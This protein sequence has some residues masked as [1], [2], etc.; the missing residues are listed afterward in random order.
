M[1][2]LKEYEAK[3]IHKYL[4]LSTYDYS[5]TNVENNGHFTIAEVQEFTSLMGTQNEYSLYLKDG[6]L[7]NTDG[8]TLACIYGTYAADSDITFIM[9]DVFHDNEVSITEVLGFVYGNETEN[10]EVLYKYIGE[11]RAEFD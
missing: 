8:D 6:K 9:F 5:I 7:E 11:L 2:K 3:I 1:Y 10:N 4:H